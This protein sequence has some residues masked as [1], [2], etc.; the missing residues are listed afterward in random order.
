MSLSD[1]VFLARLAALCDVYNVLSAG[2][3]GVQNLQRPPWE[4]SE[5]YTATTASILRMKTSLQQHIEPVSGLAR[6]EP[7][8]DSLESCWPHLANHRTALKAQVRQFP[9]CER[10][11]P[12]FRD[13]QQKR[14]SSKAR[15]LSPCLQCRLR[16]V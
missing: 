11:S 16:L 9:C 13:G 10:R 15:R 6:T 7:S 14:C 12:S 2:C 8:E 1:E 5:A 3:E 4:T